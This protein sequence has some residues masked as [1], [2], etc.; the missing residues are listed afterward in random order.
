MTVKTEPLGTGAHLFSEQDGFLSRETITLLAGTAYAAG[1]VLGKITASGKYT[2][3][4]N[5]A[6]DGTQVAAG[7]LF[8][9]VDATAADAPGV[10]HVRLCEVITSR[11]TWKSG[12]SAGDKTAGLADMAA[13]Y[14][15]GR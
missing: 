13:A 3:Y 6:S 10:A 15:I 8:A 1:S 12:A 9:A 11:L 5:A 4:D 2:L 14:L 7:V